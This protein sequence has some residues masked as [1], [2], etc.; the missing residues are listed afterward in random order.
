MQTTLNNININ[1]LININLMSQK[2][3][4]KNAQIPNSALFHQKAYRTIDEKDFGH[5]SAKNV[6]AIMQ[7]PDEGTIF[8]QAKTVLN[9]NGYILLS[10]N[11][12][13]GLDCFFYNSASGL[14]GTNINSH[15]LFMFLMG[16]VRVEKNDAKLD[17]AI[18]YLVVNW[19]SSW[20]NIQNG[21]RYF[22]SSTAKACATISFSVSQKFVSSAEPVFEIELDE[23]DTFDSIV[24]EMGWD[25]VGDYTP[26]INPKYTESKVEQFLK[27]VNVPVREPVNKAELK[28]KAKKKTEEYAN[29]DYSIYSNEEIEEFDDFLKSCYLN[30][31]EEFEKTKEFL[32]AKD[33]RNISAL[34]NGTVRSLCLLGAAGT[35]K[36]T[37]LR[38]YAGA[39]NMPFIIV[40][41]SAG[42]E[43]ASLFGSWQLRAN[44]NGTGTIMKWVDGPLTIAIR[45]GA[46]VLF[47]EENAANSGVVMKLNSILDNSRCILLDSGE[48]VN[49]HPN[50]RYAAAMNIGSGYEGTGKSNLS[51][52]DRMNRIIKIKTKTE[53]EMTDIVEKRTGYHNREHLVKMSRICKSISEHIKN[54][55][56]DASEMIT[57]IRRIIDWVYEA[58]QTGEFLTSA[59]DTIISYICIYDDTIE[60]VVEEDVLSSDGLAYIVYNEVIAELASEVFDYDSYKPEG[61]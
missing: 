57:S 25:I 32:T 20:G 6:K 8:L 26:Y 1:K 31:K 52:F 45:K 24:E 11:G 47:D 39:L 54:G 46:F 10:K 42:I 35:G 58:E 37:L 14:Y 2:G 22:D 40:G 17:E 51:H 59:L 9:Q 15:L 23:N 7:M 30:A 44:P 21:K 34:H 60:E 43:E 27:N 13:K 49:V 3:M 18:S 48:L 28:I 56:G 16:I 53:E 61:I 5:L 38:T 41:G 36:T 33:W 50:F 19:D 4:S 12:S 55:D 29:K